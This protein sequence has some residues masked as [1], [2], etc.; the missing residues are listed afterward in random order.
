[1]GN[2]GGGELLVILLVAL[3][4]LGPTKLPVAVRQ[5]GRVLGE[6]RRISAGFQ[7]ELR[8]AAEP[9]MEPVRE[10]KATLKAADRELR[11]TKS[12]LS[13]PA[14]SSAAPTPELREPKPP[15]NNSA[16]APDARSTS[17]SSSASDEP[18]RSNSAFAPDAREPASDSDAAMSPGSDAAATSSDA[19]IKPGTEPDE[20]SDGSL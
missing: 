13:K 3:I 20:R 5:V 15:R 10:T 2:L 8:D 12:T 18:P 11:D 14:A 16:F 7:Q 4:V 1:V 9:L 6:L 19:S 17:T